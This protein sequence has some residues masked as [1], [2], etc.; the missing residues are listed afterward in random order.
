[1]TRYALVVVP[2]EG[3]IAVVDDPRDH[4]VRATVIARGSAPELVI[5]AA[6]CC[7]AAEVHDLRDRLGHVNR[8]LGRREN[9][10]ALAAGG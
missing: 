10:A 3:E 5:A 6:R 2:E 1:V 8:E 7:T 9:E 4:P